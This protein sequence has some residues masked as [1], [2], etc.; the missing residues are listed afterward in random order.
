MIGYAEPGGDEGS[1]QNFQSAS[2]EYELAIV[3]HRVQYS[4]ALFSPLHTYTTIPPTD[5]LDMFI[6]KIPSWEKTEIL[7]NVR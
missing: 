2:K 1:R 3:P 7:I 6:K 5:N 4:Y